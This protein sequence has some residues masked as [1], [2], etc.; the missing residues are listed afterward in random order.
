MISSIDSL[1]RPKVWMA[2]RPAVRV[3]EQRV[4]MFQEG[5]WWA[6]VVSMSVILAGMACVVA[7]F[8]F[9]QPFLGLWK[10]F[11]GVMMIVVI[12][13]ALWF[14]KEGP[15]LIFDRR[16]ASLSIPGHRLIVPASA[17]AQFHVR[18]VRCPDGE[19]GTYVAAAL[20][21]DSDASHALFCIYVWSRAALEVVWF[22]FRSEVEKMMSEPF[23]PTRAGAVE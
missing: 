17:L 6:P 2:R 19:G 5:R 12:G 22:Q 3:L 8:D 1:N 4:E 7:H 14:R 20:V 21:L 15:I 23:L 10:S 18:D 9:T 11:G 16:N 13:M